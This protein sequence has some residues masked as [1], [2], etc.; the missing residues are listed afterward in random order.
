MAWIT[1]TLT[2]CQTRLTGSEWTSLSTAAK[3]SGQS[4]EAMAQQVI[5][6]NVTK[7]RGRVPSVVKLGAAGTIP[8]EVLGAFLA[9]WVYDFITRL[10]A[11]KS[12][13]D[14]LRVKSWEAANSELRDLANGKINLVPPVDAAPAA[15]QPVNHGVEIARQAS[16]VQDMR[17]AGLL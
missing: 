3:S 2:L 13:L 6:T 15:E 12:L 5:D 9:L 17:C 16:T 14:D 8:D 1:P 11:M 4:A 10:P 7:V